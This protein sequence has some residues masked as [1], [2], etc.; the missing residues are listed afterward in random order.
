MPPFPPGVDPSR[1]VSPPALRPS[2][3]AL[4]QAMTTCVDQLRLTATVSVEGEE[5]MDWTHPKAGYWCAEQ[6]IRVGRISAK[7]VSRSY[8]KEHG[9]YEPDDDPLGYR[10]RVELE[11]TDPRFAG[12]KGDITNGGPFAALD[13]AKLEAERWAGE[14]ERKYAQLAP[15]SR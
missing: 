12:R 11:F 7:V 10:A 5:R 9:H 8:L 6:P 15:A 13:L 3:P 2:E 1:C 14:I 4:A